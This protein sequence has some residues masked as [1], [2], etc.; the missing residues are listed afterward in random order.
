MLLAERR[1][2]DVAAATGAAVG[3]VRNGVL[4]V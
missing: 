1:V 4:A 2:V 3:A